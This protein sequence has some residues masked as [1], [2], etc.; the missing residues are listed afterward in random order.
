[1]RKKITL[2]F[3]IACIGLAAV[4]VYLAIP[5]VSWGSSPKMPFAAV[6]FIIG[7]MGS[8]ISAIIYEILPTKMK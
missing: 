7:V 6:T 8:F 4:S 1:M 2:A 3:L 5:A